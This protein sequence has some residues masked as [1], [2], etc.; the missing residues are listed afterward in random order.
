MAAKFYLGFHI[1]KFS[2]AR[3]Q[4]KLGRGFDCDIR[5]NDISV[6][7]SHAIIKLEKGNFYL[8]DS[9][10]KFGTLLLMQENQINFL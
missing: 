4:I 1:M 8:Q 10:S 3:A 9:N 7:R 2:G 6:S 5:I